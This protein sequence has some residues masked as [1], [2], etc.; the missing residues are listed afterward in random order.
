MPGV[1]AAET[2]PGGAVV[3]VE[4]DVV[5]NGT[6]VRGIVGNGGRTVVGVV[7]DGNGGT[8]VGSAGATAV[9]AT[10][11]NPEAPTLTDAGVVR[12]DVSAVAARVR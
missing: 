9:L 8:V 5:T 12:K 11:A 3:V 6:V 2:G 1:S 10:I 7:T 4:D